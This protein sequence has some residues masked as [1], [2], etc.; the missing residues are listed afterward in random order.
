MLSPRRTI[1]I[2]L[3][4]L[5]CS[6][7]VSAAAARPSSPSSLQALLSRLERYVAA[8]EPALSYLVAREHFVQ[9]LVREPA[10]P[11]PE[12]RTRESRRET[13]SDYLFLRLPGEDGPWLGI[14]DVLEMDGVRM[15]PPTERL[16]EITSAAPASVRRQA[17]AMARE[18][19]RYNLGPVYRTVNVPTAVLSWMH[20]QFRSRFSFRKVAE[21]DMS[22]LRVWKLV[23]SERRRPTI[24]RTPQGRHVV[25]KGHIWVDPADG[26]LLRSEL[27]NEIGSLAVSIEVQFARDERF[28]MLLPVSMKERYADGDMVLETEARYSDYR[29]FDVNTRIR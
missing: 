5:L 1:G 29:R 16:Q 11:T 15:T 6:C 3:S 17:E 7:A 2:V 12:P 10:S 18:N 28:D 20:P 14:R 27:S 21:E 4:V 26:R 13:V 19:A 25:S 8:Y 22:G 24:V 23:F 9:R